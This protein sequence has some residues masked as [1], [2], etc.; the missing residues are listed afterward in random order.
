VFDD[1]VDEGNIGQRPERLATLLDMMLPATDAAPPVAN[2]P[3]ATALGDL[4]RRIEPRM[5]QAWCHRFLQHVAE[6]SQ[7][8]RRKTGLASVAR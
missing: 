5:P 7:G 8:G 2:H 1:Q 6:Y 4:W 3:L